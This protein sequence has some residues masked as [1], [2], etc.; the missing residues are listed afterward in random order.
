MGIGETATLSI[1]PKFVEITKATQK[2]RVFASLGKT[3]IIHLWRS[4]FHK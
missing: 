1:V 4:L 3:Y 2:M